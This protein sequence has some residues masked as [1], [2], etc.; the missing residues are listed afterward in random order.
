MTK[1]SKSRTM[2]YLRV[3][4]KDQDNDKFKQD[5]RAFANS[6]DFGR[7]TF[8]EEKISGKKSWRTRRIAT[9]IDE[10][11]AGD[12]LLVSELSRLGRSTLEVLEILKAAQEKGIAI[13]SVKENYQLNGDGLQAKMMSTMLALFS[14][15]EHAFISERTKEGLQAARAKG[16][17]LGRPKGPG[18]SKLD[19]HRDEIIDKLRLG[20]PKTKIARRYKTTPANFYNWLRQ[21][22][23]KVKEEVID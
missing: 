9:L 2:S 20:V 15:V 22:Q 10:M 18:K 7:V 14:D 12:R 23:V 3:S 19:P 5:I 1:K 21:N 13:Y 11:K 4:T 6:K 8:V 17:R 16:V